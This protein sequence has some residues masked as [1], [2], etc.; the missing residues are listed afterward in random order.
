[1][2]ITYLD[3]YFYYKLPHNDPES[4]NDPDIMANNEVNDQQ[5][6]INIITLDDLIETKE[7]LMDDLNALSVIENN[8]RIE[9]LIEPAKQLL[10]EWVDKIEENQATFTITLIPKDYVVTRETQTGF[11]FDYPN[12]VYMINIETFPNPDVTHHIDINCCP[13]SSVQDSNQL[14]SYTA[15]VELEMSGTQCRGAHIETLVWT[16]PQS[17]QFKLPVDTGYAVGEGTICKH[18]YLQY[19]VRESN[20]EPFLDYVKLTFTKKTVKRF[21]QVTYFNIS[22]FSIPQDENLWWVK[23]T[24][25]YTGHFTLTGFA[26]KLHTHQYGRP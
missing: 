16:Y 20:P 25:Q 24:H 14:P 8:V 7:R 3:L 26:Y 5:S 21:S 2:C 10:D 12:D 6:E 17:H 18:G 19:H 1:M 9:N 11:P 13:S 15:E 23:Q 4:L 22:G